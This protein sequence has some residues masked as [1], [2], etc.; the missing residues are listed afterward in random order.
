VIAAQHD[1]VSADARMGA[2]ARRSRV[3]KTRYGSRDHDRSSHLIA[4]VVAGESARTISRPFLRDRLPDYMIPSAI[5]RLDALPLT[6]N[7]KVDRRRLPEPDRASP[8][9]DYVAPRTPTEIVIARIW[10]NVLQVERTGSLDN[11]FEL[12]GHS[13]LATR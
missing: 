1:D 6:A 4:Y 3:A 13:L 9:T 12:G 2:I 8:A 10:T 11:F 5:V 7:G